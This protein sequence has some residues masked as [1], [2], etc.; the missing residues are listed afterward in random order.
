MK[1]CN[2]C[3]LPDSRPNISIMSDGK[4]TACHNHSN[5]KKINWKNKKKEFDRIVKK[6]KKAKS[7]KKIVVV[8]EHANNT[9]LQSG[10]WTIAWQGTTENYKG[11]T[12]ILKGIQQ[13]ATGTVVFDK[14]ATGNHFDADVA[15]VVVGETPYAEFFGDIGDGTGKYQLTLSKKHQNYI[16]RYVDK[17]VPVITVLISGRPLVTTHQITQ[18]NA[19]VAAW[20][21]G[22]EGDGIAEVLF[23]EE[24]FTGKLPHSWP[25]SIDDFNG[26]YGPNFWDKTIQPLYPFGFGLQYKNIK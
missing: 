2:N 18:S 1:Y 23:G 9:G 3:V 24:N 6:I 8:G 11:A 13:K 4:C 7:T 21:P 10:G 12:T 20:L 15:I 17:G 14:E 25:K 16:S 5:K 19:F 26:K 22:S